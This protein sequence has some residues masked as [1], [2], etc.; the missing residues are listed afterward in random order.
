ML[1]F[2]QR[3]SLPGSI[4]TIAFWLPLLCDNHQLPS[5]TECCQ[6]PIPVHP[7]YSIPL[8]LSPQDFGDPFQS[9]SSDL[10]VVSAQFCLYPLNALAML[11]K[12]PQLNFFS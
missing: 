4:D 2:A 12:H 9:M 8:R 6:S 3:T 10:P 5:Y 7:M 1:H 11:K